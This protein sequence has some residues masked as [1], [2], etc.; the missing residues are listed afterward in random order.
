MAHVRYLKPIPVL[1]VALA[2]LAAA[3]APAA[4]PSPT[5]PPPKP[6]E[7]PK[8]A[9]PAA[10]PTEAPAAKPAEARPTEAPA[11]KPA[12]KPAEKFPSRPIQWIVPYGP[13]AYDTLSRGL[14]PILSKELGVPVVVENV[15]GAEGFNR[16]A[17]AAPDGHTLGAAELVGEYFARIVQQ[18]VYDVTKFTVLGRFNESVNLVAASPRAPFRTLQEL[19]NAKEPV[20]C[21]LFG[22]FG[23]PVA[24]CFLTMEAF[25]IP[26]SFVKLASPAEAV[27][28]VT[29]GD[30][31][32]LSAGT[33]LWLDHIAKGNAV[34]L[35]VWSTEADPRLPGTPTLR[36]AGLPELAPISN[37]RT[38]VAPPGTPP[39]RVEAL[40]TAIGNAIKTAE[41]Q[42]FLKKG[43]FETNTLMGEPFRKL[44]ADLTAVVNKHQD[45]AR[46]AAAKA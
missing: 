34:P 28:G 9:A 2:L 6:T 40:T 8:P 20:R 27:L 31:D 42:D 41:Y 25:G 45:A 3:C 44:L 12:A 22:G 43:N 29:R 7:A 1:A 11:A 33:V 30:A 10:K 15:P 14:A 32:V 46:R 13:G 38:I 5:A 23:V 21:G 26:Y 36:E 19:K 18:P 37:Q 17:R 35:M 24:H 16:I 39:E 4:P